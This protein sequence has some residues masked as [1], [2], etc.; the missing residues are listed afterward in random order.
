MM[1]RLG[2]ACLMFLLP[3]RALAADPPP[4]PTLQQPAGPA[5]VNP[6]GGTG[7]LLRPIL[8]TRTTPPYPAESQ[9]LGEQGTTMLRV[10]IAPD[11]TVADASVAT[12]SGSARLDQAAMD[13][14]K[15]TYR[16]EKLDCAVPVATLVRIVWSLRTPA[17]RTPLDPALLPKMAHFIVAGGDEYP[18]GAPKTRAITMAIVVLGDDGQVGQVLIARG[19]GNAALDDRAQALIRAR[20][21]TAAYDGQRPVGSLVSVVVV[22]SPPGQKEPDPEQLRSMLQMYMDQ[23]PPPP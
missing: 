6:C 12:G 20:H 22:W 15:Q 11:G 23:A 19:S 10:Q 13:F 2:V 3:L 1:R 8:S 18:A 5:N 21:W 7:P 4:T 9:R 16:W 17:L 14:V